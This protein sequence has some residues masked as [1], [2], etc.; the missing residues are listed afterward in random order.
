MG[1]A[2]RGPIDKAVN[3]LNYSKY[4]KNFGGLDAESEMSYAV[5]QFFVNG[6]AN[7][8]VVRLVKSASAATQTFKNATDENVLTIT[9]Q[10]KGASGRN[11]EVQINYQTSNPA[12][13]F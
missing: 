12:S 2:K 3:I 10:D 13:T 4:E 7:A 1:K 6:G 9:A 8:W 11:I 5:K